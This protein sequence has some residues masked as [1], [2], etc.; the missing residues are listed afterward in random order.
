[1]RLYLGQPLRLLDFDSE[2]LIRLLNIIALLKIVGEY[3]VSDLG[4]ELLLVERVVETLHNEGL[5]TLV[6]QQ[7]HVVRLSVVLQ[8]ELGLQ[9]RSILLKLVPVLSP[10]V[11]VFLPQR[12]KV[13]RNSAILA[14]QH[15]LGF[16]DFLR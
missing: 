8:I 9:S 3:L 14:S 13:R 16:L 12:F 15:F 6:P 2:A 1:M 11:T 4:Q 5:R 7:K 10:V